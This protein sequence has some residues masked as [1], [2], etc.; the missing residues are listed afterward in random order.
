MEHERC[1]ACGF[2]GAIFDA[3]ALV[4]ALRDLGPAWRE[5]LGSAGD[6]L[7]T[8]PAPG[9]WSAIEYAEHTRDITALHVFG[10]EQALMFDEPQL[11]QLADDLVDSGAA[12]YGEADPDQVLAEIAEQ[13]ATL[14]RLARFAQAGGDGWRRGL[15]VGSDRL[16]VRWL[17]EHALH[18]S[19]HHLFDVRRGLTQMRRA[20]GDELVGITWQLRAG[21]PLGVPLGDAVVTAHFD[22]R[23]VFGTSGCNA[24]TASFE[25]HGAALRVGPAIAATRRRCGPVED[26][27]EHDYLQRLGQ[28]TAYNTGGDTLS[29]VGADG[30]ELLRFGAVDP[31][32]AI[33][34]SWVVTSYLAPNAVTSVVGDVEITLELGADD[35]TGHT[36]CNRFTGTY[37]L[38]G[39]SIAIRPLVVTATARLD[40]AIMRQEHH[41]LSALALATTVRVAG[42]RL[43]LLRGG[44]TYA[45]TAQRR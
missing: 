3:S 19:R 10:V 38:E 29:L 23:R 17:I 18:D 24:Y 16:E 13:T 39:D 21:S 14:A 12:A 35:V 34:G 37:H 31:T 8:R 7:R 42:P 41:F 20:T 6:L 36:G 33:R 9:V 43:D 1:T 4:T 30:G 5:L 25:R 45:V 27:V 28:V 32:A 26:A 15:T 11:P 44:G 22:G 40:D 2:D